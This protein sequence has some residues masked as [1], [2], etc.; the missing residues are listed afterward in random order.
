M[1]TNKTNVLLCWMS[2]CN[3][4]ND[5]WAV[6]YNWSHL[7]WWWGNFWNS[8]LSLIS[9]PICVSQPYT[10]EPDAHQMHLM[11]IFIRTCTFCPT[12]LWHATQRHILWMIKYT[13]TKQPLRTLAQFCTMGERTS[14]HVWPHTSE[15]TW[16]QSAVGE[17][18]NM[19]CFVWFCVCIWEMYY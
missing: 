7:P 11:L 17:I 8:S 6:H 16:L 9:V 14:L 15:V 18:Q 4:R 3:S 1:C 19:L 2:N 12:E 13:L 5:E 10:H